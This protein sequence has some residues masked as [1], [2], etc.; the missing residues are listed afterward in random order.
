M[1]YGK[2]AK[3]PDG[4]YFLRITSSKDGGRVLK[5]VNGVEVQE[6]AGFFKVPK[7][8]E[9]VLQE[10]DDSILAQAD[11]MSEEWFGRK[12]ESDALKKAYDPSVSSGL[13]EAPL[14]RVNSNVVAKVFDSDRKEVQDP[15][16]ALSAPGTKCD[17][18]VELVG[19]WFLKKSF[20]PVWRLVQARIVSG[21]PVSKFPQ[22]YMFEDHQEEEEDFS[23]LF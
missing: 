22:E 12:I 19:L 6:P 16:A 20:G 17:I 3:L 5:Q 10:Y 18:I 7:S 21:S 15:E 4:R 9:S 23:S 8:V 14:A 1:E 11:T 13:L 2:P